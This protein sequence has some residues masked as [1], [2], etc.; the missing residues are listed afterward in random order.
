ML[1]ADFCGLGVAMN[2][3]HLLRPVS[4]VF[5]SSTTQIRWQGHQSPVASHL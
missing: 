4:L 5:I 2:S 1:H 3:A